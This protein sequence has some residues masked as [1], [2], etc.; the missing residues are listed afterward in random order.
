M[1]IFTWLFAPLPPLLY[2][3]YDKLV[4]IPN[5]I[6]GEKA[7]SECEEKQR[8][9]K[10]PTPFHLLT[11]SLFHLFTFSP[12]HPFTFSLF[13]PSIPI[14]FKAYQTEKPLHPF[15]SSLSCAFS[16]NYLSLHIQEVLPYEKIYNSILRF[17]P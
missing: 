3:S 6:K 9:K 7:R 1:L 17:D 4:V 13:H 10:Q 11:L 5:Y 8:Y 15:N 14:S 16:E 12:F 2:A